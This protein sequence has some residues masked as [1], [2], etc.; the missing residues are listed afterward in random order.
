MTINRRI[1]FRTPGLLDMRA[2]TTFGINAKP[3]TDSPIGFFGTG[4]KYAIAVCMREKLSLSIWV[5]KTRYHFATESEEFRDKEFGFIYMTHYTKL[6]RR[7][8][9]ERLPFTTELGKTWELWQAFREL[10][11]NTLDEDGV[12]DLE[13]NFDIAAFL[14]ER[15][16][17]ST[18]IVVGGEAFVQEFLDK[19]KTFLLAGSRNRTGASVEHFFEPCKHVYYRGMRVMDLDKPSILTYNILAPIDLTEDRTA[20]YPHQVENWIKEYV[21]KSIDEELVRAVIDAKDGAYENRFDFDS[22]IYDTPKAT[23][24]QYARDSYRSQTTY[25]PTIRKYMETYDEPTRRE[26]SEAVIWKPLAVALMAAIDNT[27]W[28]KVKDI[29]Q[30]RSE[31]F[32]DL[33]TAAPEQF[34]TIKKVELESDAQTANDNEAPELSAQDYQDGAV[35]K[36]ESIHIDDTEVPC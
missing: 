25:N 28:Y 9:E 24:A 10:Y 16:D 31:E 12:T 22:G 5:G 17:N 18:V 23:F 26:V 6:L 19:D 27:D 21:V 32:K 34:W 33:L 1:I 8:K 20:K 3:N 4:L 15:D 13:P 36:V 11:S 30:E 7:A 2:V 29:I 35:A 14:S